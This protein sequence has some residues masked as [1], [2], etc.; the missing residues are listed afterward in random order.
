M[1]VKQMT[2]ASSKA[3]GVGADNAPRSFTGLT[4][5]QLGAK[6]NANRAT[7]KQITAD[8]MNVKKQV[9]KVMSSIENVETKKRQYSAKKDRA[10][11][12]QRQSPK[13]NEV[14]P[15]ELTNLKDKEE[16][17]PQSHAL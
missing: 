16:S 13:N 9:D 8:L 3:T 10:K 12:F 15:P 1:D 4:S 6:R 17:G 7:D 14:P 5:S 11:M 2:H